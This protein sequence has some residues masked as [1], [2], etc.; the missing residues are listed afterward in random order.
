MGQS[1][2]LEY[3]PNQV[4]HALPVVSLGCAV[5]MHIGLKG[6]VVSR[7]ALHTTTSRARLV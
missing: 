7:S 4:R 6:V 1:A 5:S 2:G 3:F